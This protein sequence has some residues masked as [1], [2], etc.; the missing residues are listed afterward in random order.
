MDDGIVMERDLKI[1]FAGPVWPEGIA[2]VLFSETMAGELHAL[3]TAAYAKG[4]GDVLP[5]N[6]WWRELTADP[7]YD[8]ELLFVAQ[9][10]Q[11]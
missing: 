11:W 7:E 1:P 6:Q 3:L 9:A 10:P 2:P 5:F 8:A 4:E